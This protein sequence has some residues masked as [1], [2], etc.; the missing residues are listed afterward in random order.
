MLE[1]PVGAE[2]CVTLCDLRVRVDKAAETIM[3]K[4]TNSV[5]GSYRPPSQW[6]AVRHHGRVMAPHTG[7]AIPELRVQWE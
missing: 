2:K 4:D 5:A 6:C 7:D 1:R 3:S